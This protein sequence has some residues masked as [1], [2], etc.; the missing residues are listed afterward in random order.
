VDKAWTAFVAAKKAE[1]LSRII[2]E[3]GLDP[4]KTKSFIEDAFRD[5]DIPRTG[6]AI[7]KIL[8]PASRFS[9]DNAH[10][11]KKRAV[12]SKLLAFFSRYFSLGA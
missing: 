1:G 10:A 5:G 7:T 3:E 9:P 4:E 8:P 2:A 11:T 6:V 12:L